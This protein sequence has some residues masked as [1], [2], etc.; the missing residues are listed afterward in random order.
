MKKSLFQYILFGLSIVVFLSASACKGNKG[1]SK[2]SVKNKSAKFLVKKI[3][4]DYLDADWLN[5]KARINFKSDEIS[6]GAT[7]LLRMRKDSA[8]WMSGKKFGIEGVRVLITPDSV[9]MLDRLNNE[10][11]TKD[12]HWVREQF[13]LPADF[14][15]LQNILL[16]NIVLLPEAKQLNASVDK[17]QYHLSEKEPMTLSKDYWINGFNYAP[18][19][20]EFKM[21]AEGR[22]A[23]VEYSQHAKVDQLGDFPYHRFF[24]FKS[25][26]TGDVTLD[27][28]FSKVEVNV[29]KSMKFSVPGHYDL[30]D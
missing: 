18:E 13:S 21:E 16:G 12:L 24:S 26:E 11:R 7:L 15:D 1:T 10:Y 14:N 2:G 30:V 29:P 20:M 9:F 3:R 5:A 17:K 6:Q 27:M 23:M 8:I 22:N 4:Q 25:P 28:K 19:R